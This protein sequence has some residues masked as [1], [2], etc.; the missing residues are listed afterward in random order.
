[1]GVA[2]T[3]ER[4]E[5][6]PSTPT[7]RAETV[8]LEAD[9]PKATS[10]G[11]AQRESLAVLRMGMAET[12]ERGEDSQST[13]TARA[14]TVGLEANPPGAT[15]GGPPQRESLAV[16]RM[17]MAETGE[18]GEDAG[19]GGLHPRALTE[20]A[21]EARRIERLL[22]CSSDA[23]TMA[24]RSRSPDGKDGFCSFAASATS[25]ASSCSASCVSGA[26]AIPA[27]FI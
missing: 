10:G 5:D 26:A 17:G 9:P 22:A 19:D 21:R 13:P 15:S 11:V 20:A 27:R 14:E 25:A 3:G 1:M 18:R 16:L 12:G 6:A 8:G 23:K 2:R 4:G 7:A 24:V